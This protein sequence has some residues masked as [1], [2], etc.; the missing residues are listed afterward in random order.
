MKFYLLTYLDEN[1]KYE[2][3]N[4]VAPNAKTALEFLK[5]SQIFISLTLKLN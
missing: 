3:A 2:T 1:E 5:D 4:I